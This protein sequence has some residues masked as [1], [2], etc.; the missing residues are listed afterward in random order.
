MR[1]DSL[2]AVGTPEV[3]IC[4][5]TKD[6]SALSDPAT[7]ENVACP[8]SQWKECVKT[9]AGN[10]KSH[11]VGANIVRLDH[12]V[13]VVVIDVAPATKLNVQFTPVLL[14]AYTVP[15]N[16]GQD[17]G[18]FEVRNIAHPKTVSSVA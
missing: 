17:G 2:P 12:I 15:T 8:G 16:K 9:P 3:N 13:R 5:F 14:R 11:N 7:V 10:S 6:V 4:S 18:R 1:A